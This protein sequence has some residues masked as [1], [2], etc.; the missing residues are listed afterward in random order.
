M[1]IYLNDSCFENSIRDLTL[2]KKSCEGF[3]LVWIKNSIFFAE[4]STASRISPRSLVQQN[5]Q[6]C[7][8]R[9]LLFIAVMH[10]FITIVLT[11]LF[12]ITMFTSFIATT[13]KRPYN[14]CP[15]ANLNWQTFT[16]V[17]VI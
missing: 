11:V 13:R 2:D 7:I 1:V 5:T 12:N 8:C 9:F 6:D 3:L 17:F 14:V 16:I 15:A 4:C 10:P